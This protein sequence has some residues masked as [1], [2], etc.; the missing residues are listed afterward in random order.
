MGLF[1]K[2]YHTVQSS[3]WTIFR[4]SLFITQTLALNASVES[5][6]NT[7]VNTKNAPAIE[8]KRLVQ[9]NYTVF[10]RNYSTS[11]TFRRTSESG[12]ESLIIICIVIIGLSI[13]SIGSFYCNFEVYQQPR[14]KYKK[15]LEESELV[16]INLFESDVED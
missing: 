13:I 10:E 9:Y 4:L 2:R 6:Q 5:I 14:K 1:A 12:K 8:V 16:E 15:V 7:T 3:L 11:P